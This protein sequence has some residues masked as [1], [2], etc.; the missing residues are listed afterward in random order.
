[1]AARMVTCS[2]CEDEVPLS[3]AK[4]VDGEVLCSICAEDDGEEDE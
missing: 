3:E 2:F 4:N 1:M